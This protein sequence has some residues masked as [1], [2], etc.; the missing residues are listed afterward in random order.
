MMA[1]AIGY[2]SQLSLL[3]GIVLIFSGA[4]GVLRF[5]D[6][7]TRIHAA[8]VTET[9]AAGLILVG[10]MLEAGWTLAFL[11]LAMIFVFVMIT[12][13]TATHALTKA[14]VHGGLK[15]LEREPGKPWPAPP[16]RDGN[17]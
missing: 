1:L 4:L 8:G 13:P 10:L 3:L 16:G 11:K 17:R 7:Y 12:S 15:P 14:A 5:P 9:L 6:F 2:L